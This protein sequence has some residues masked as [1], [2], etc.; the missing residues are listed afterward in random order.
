PLMMYSDDT[1]GN[2][3]KKWNKHLGFY[4]TLAGFPLKLI[5]QEYNIHYATFSNT[6]GALEL[7]DPVIDELK[8]LANQGFKAFDAGLNSEVHVMVIG[9][10]HLGDSPMHTDVSKTTN[11][12]TTLNPCHTCHLTVE[13]KAGKQTEAYVHSLLGINS[14]GKL[15]CVLLCYYQLAS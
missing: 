12:S 11:P 15:V 1:S 6:A 4:Y 13:T 7:A 10:C 9:L 14:S 2:H 8:K 5:N 3:S